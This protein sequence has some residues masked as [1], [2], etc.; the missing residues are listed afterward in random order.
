MQAKVIHVDLPDEATRGRLRVELS[1]VPQVDAE[2]P[3]VELRAP[4]GF[5]PA[6]CAPPPVGVPRRADFAAPG[7]FLPS[8][9]ISRTFANGVRSGAA[10]RPSSPCG[11]VADRSL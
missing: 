10:W 7:R 3:S 2:P 11:E 6:D 1:L 9:C 8:D 5:M 4:R